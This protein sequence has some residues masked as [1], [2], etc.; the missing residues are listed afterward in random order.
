MALIRNHV[1]AY[2]NDD[3]NLLILYLRAAVDYMQEI[4]N[5]ILGE[6][7]VTIKLSKSEI[8]RPVIIPKVQDIN[9]FY[10]LKYRT[11]DSD[12]IMPYADAYS[13][14]LDDLTANEPAD[15]VSLVAGERSY[16]LG[17]PVFPVPDP[18]TR[19]TTSV[20]LT[21]TG[22][23]ADFTPA[24]YLQSLFKW[25]TESNTYVAS[26]VASTNPTFVQGNRQFTDNENLPRGLYKFEE[27]L[28]DAASNERVSNFYFVVTD[29][30]DLFDCQVIDDR[31]P[32]YLDISKLCTLP[33]DASSYD[34]DYV[35]VVVGAGTPYGELPRQYGQA[36]L[37][38]V[39]HYY[40][41]RE[42]ENIGG[43]TSEVKEGVHRLIQSVRQY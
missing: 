30:T 25:D 22:A 24:T 4:S 29:G 19:D 9:Q 33:E 13:F 28:I 6:S 21:T 39:G 12:G 34:E 23:P 20:T 8:Q 16:Q 31:Y 27:K 17:L 35:E 37:L 5:R 7:V 11:K 38:L 32:I 36:A 26:T 2:D 1:R 43:I 15:G 10:S 41:M 42:A 3:D 14:Y 40:N 18:D